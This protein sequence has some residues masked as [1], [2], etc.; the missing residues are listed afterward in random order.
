MFLLY[1]KIRNFFR[2]FF[3]YK[4]K[5][6]AFIN[7]EFQLINLIELIIRKKIHNHEIIIFIGFGRP[8]YLILENYLKILRNLN[9]K[10]NIYKININSFFFFFNYN[11]SSLQE[12]Q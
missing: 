8:E 2:I 7:S 9:I 11:Y 6:L 4:R 3:L 5:N 12:V 1:Y 10:I